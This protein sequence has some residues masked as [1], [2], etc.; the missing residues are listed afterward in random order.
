[1]L[2][3][4]MCVLVRLHM[5]L[6]V[7]RQLVP[8]RLVAARLL[9]LWCVA[10]LALPATVVQAQRKVHINVTVRTFCFLSLWKA[11][12]TP[13]RGPPVTASVFE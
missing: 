1:M 10:L 12:V 13:C 2:F 7:S 6:T 11:S 4:C 9:L 3:V 8:P 5:C